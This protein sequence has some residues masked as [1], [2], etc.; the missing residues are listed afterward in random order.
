MGAVFVV[1]F[2]L[3]VVIMAVVV[4]LIVRSAIG[5]DRTVNRDRAQARRAAAGPGG[6][7]PGQADH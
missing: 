7:G 3:F 1:A 2:A 4:G 6:E 5:R